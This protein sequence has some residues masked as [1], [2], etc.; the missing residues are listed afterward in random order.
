MIDSE[1]FRIR[2]GIFAGRSSSCK[3]KSSNK[4]NL[5]LLEMLNEGIIKMTCKGA[6]VSSGNV[7]GCIIIFMI[8][9]VVLY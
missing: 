6:M 5:I 3:Y 9:T 4:F 8:N 7:C 1:L 2:I